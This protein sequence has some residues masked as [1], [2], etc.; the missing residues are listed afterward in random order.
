[1]ITRTLTLALA[2]LLA[3]SAYAAPSKSGKNRDHAAESIAAPTED[4]IRTYTYNRDIIFKLYGTVN[5]HIHV[6]LEEG[7]S[8]A[9]KPIM[10]DTVQWRFTGGGR[11]L[12]FKPTNAGINTTLTV[13]TTKRTYEF[14]LIS[15]N[16]E[17]SVY[18]KIIFDYPD[19]ELEFKFQAT[20]VVNAQK[21][22]SARLTSQVIQPSV[23]PTS[24]NYDYDIS[25]NAPWKPLDVS[26]DDRFTYIRMPITQAS[27]AVF[28]LDGDN[29]PSLVAFRPKGNYIV[30]ERLANA[31]L[32]KIGTEEVRITK[33]GAAKSIWQNTGNRDAY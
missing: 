12:F 3:T 23:D 32:M 5:K 17:R 27:P 11:H 21:A 15:V 31:L 6:E 1:M 7:E 28:L 4:R 9:Y 18:Q 13:I 14:E 10:G 25:G 29:K 22:E 2:A 19:S 26:S 8:L 20:Q 33:R 24:F 16:E 30:V